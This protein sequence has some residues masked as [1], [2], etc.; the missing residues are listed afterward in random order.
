[1]LSWCQNRKWIFVYYDVREEEMT[2]SSRSFFPN[3]TANT[4]PWEGWQDYRVPFALVKKRAGGK[5]CTQVF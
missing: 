2:N 1:M 4:V 5:K 3:P